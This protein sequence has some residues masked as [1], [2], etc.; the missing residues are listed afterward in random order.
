MCVCFLKCVYCVGY[1]EQHMADVAEQDFDPSPCER[2]PSPPPLSSGY[3]YPPKKRRADAITGDFQKCYTKLCM[4]NCVWCMISCMTLFSP[5][6]IPYCIN[7]FVCL[8]N[9][10]DVNKCMITNK[11]DSGIL[12]IQMSLFGSLHHILETCM[13]CGL[14]GLLDLCDCTGWQWNPTR[15]PCN[16]KHHFTNCRYAV[17]LSFLY[18]KE[19]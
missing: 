1:V 15:Q 17:C 14:E 3:V 10:A 12:Y 5:F 4:G 7:I 11:S 13:L 18:S 16:S 6:S 2:Q 9:I 19:M 8:K